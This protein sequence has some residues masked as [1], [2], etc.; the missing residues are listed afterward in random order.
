MGHANNGKAINVESPKNHKD[1]RSLRNFLLTNKRIIT[2][3]AQKINGINYLK[4]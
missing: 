3:K 2:T 4:L 1:E